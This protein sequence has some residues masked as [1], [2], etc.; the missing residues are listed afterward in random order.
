ML[1]RRQ[2]AATAS[3]LA[4][5]A[6]AHSHNAHAQGAS[7]VLRVVPQAEPLVFDPH[8][9]QAN[10]TNIHAGMVYDTLFSWDADMVPRPQMVDTWTKSNDRLLYTFHAAPGVEIS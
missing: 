1:S 9:S 5:A 10:I 8:Q 4:F 6:G 3:S 7:R 2:F